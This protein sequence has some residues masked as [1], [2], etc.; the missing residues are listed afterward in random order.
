MSTD[1]TAEERKQQAEN[2]RVRKLLE[3]LD[4]GVAPRPYNTT[5]H[6]VKR[7]LPKDDLRDDAIGVLPSTYPAEDD[8]V[9]WLEYYED[10]PIVS[11]IA[12]LALKKIRELEAEIAQLKGLK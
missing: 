8:A 11:N 3:T 5:S 12:K 1:R 2:K 10:S 4:A 7:P 9:G 6:P